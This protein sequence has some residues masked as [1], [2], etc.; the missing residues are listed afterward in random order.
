MS[1]GDKVS[2][3]SYVP[4]ER[5]VELAD[6]ELREST[7]Y[8]GDSVRDKV[9][10]VKKKQH[11]KETRMKQVQQTGANFQLKKLCEET[12]FVYMKKKKTNCTTVNSLSHQKGNLFVGKCR[13]ANARAL[14]M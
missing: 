11:K 13:A 2:E 3:L 4:S 8:M 5:N 1:N 10:T 12:R 6:V 14:A 9:Q 7:P